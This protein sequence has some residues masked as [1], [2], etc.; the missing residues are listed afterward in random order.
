MVV[1]KLGVGFAGY[2]YSFCIW[3]GVTGLEGFKGTG[4]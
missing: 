2:A 3:K 4:R 1:L